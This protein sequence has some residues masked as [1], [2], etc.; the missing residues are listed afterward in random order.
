M[1]VRQ[2][3][4]RTVRIPLDVAP[5][6]ALGEGVGAEDQDP[7]REEQLDHGVTSMARRRT[8]A[9]ACPENPSHRGMKP[10]RS[11]MV[12][13]ETVKPAAIRIA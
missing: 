3:L 10:V 9:I 1:T 13:V 2:R 5:P 8:R 7:D 11:P 12:A 4:S 6:E